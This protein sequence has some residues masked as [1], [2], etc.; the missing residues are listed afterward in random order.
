MLAKKLTMGIVLSLV[1]TVALAQL[2]EPAK[3]EETKTEKYEH[4]DNMVQV[5]HIVPERVYGEYDL[6]PEQINFPEWARRFVLN[7]DGT[8]YLEKY[9]ENKAPEHFEWGLVTEPDRLM[10]GEYTYTDNSGN[11]NTHRSYVLVIKWDSG[12]FA[13]GYIHNR[14]GRLALNGPYD[15]PMYH[16]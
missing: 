2:V 4:K 16:Q 7:P 15:A 10:V 8:G 13:S 14:D 6:P 3:V 1:A 5:T 11:R 12:S 9:G